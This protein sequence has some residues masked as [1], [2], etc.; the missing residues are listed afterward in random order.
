MR[1]G[2]RR[3]AIAIVFVA[4]VLFLAPTAPAFAANAPVGGQVAGGP[5][6][7][8]QVQF[9]IPN[10][11]F[12][13]TKWAQDAFGGLLQSF[14]DGVHA[15]MDALWD[16]NFITQTPPSLTYQNDDIRGLYGTMPTPRSRAVG[17]IS[18][19]RPRVNSDHSL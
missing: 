11:D 15:G 7:E 8:A 2:H 12:N 4:V 10:F 14:S 6:L 9:P 3:A 19:P 5:G 13:P 18:A 17:T 1:L 16:A